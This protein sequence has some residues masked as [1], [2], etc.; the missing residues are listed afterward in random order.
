MS[1]S[2]LTPLGA[3]VGLVGALAVVA[4]L[5]TIR[6]SRVVDTQLGLAPPRSRSF[7]ID[8]A[9][10]VVVSGL[11]ALACA[12]PVV[13]S[14]ARL[15]GR[16]GVEVYVVFDITR[17]MLAQRAP[18]EPNRLERA[19]SFAKELRAEIPEARVG[20]ASLTDRVL[21]HLF[22]TLSTNAFVSV[23]NRSIGIER[24]PPDRRTRRAT[25]LNALGDMGRAAYFDSLTTRRL[26]VVLTDGETLPV[27][28]ETL[29]TRLVDARVA[30]VFVHV[31]RGDERVVAADGRPDAAYRPDPTALR[32]LR[33]VAGAVDGTVF[34]EGQRREVQTVV[35]TFAAD[36]PMVEQGSELRPVELAPPIVAFT[37]LPLLVLLRRRS[38]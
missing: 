35:R 9:L 7:G 31:W 16:E 30:T 8:I 29:R 20:V 38:L 1:L 13:S 34:V 15:E 17:S 10:I 25:S 36:G 27:D 6:R 19:R 12:Q 2:F 22:P 23:V 11:V 14:S 33:R 3:V 28:F 37:L 4:L 18:S 32:S 26:V 5:R 21:P 24:P